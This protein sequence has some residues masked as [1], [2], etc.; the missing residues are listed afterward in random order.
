MDLAWWCMLAL[1]A[2]AGFWSL[3]LS[4]LFWRLRKDAERLREGVEAE[5]ARK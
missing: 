4:V 2:L 3:A 5:K 1:T